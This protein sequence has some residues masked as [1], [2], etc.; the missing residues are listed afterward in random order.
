[1]AD[2]KFYLLFNNY[3]WEDKD[4]PVK[5]AGR[6][7][8]LYQRG[9]DIIRDHALL[10]ERTGFEGI[11]FTEQHANIEG[12]PEVTANPLLL[13]LF[14]A[15]QTSRIKVG[16]LGMTLPTANPL[17]VADQIAQL[18]QL[19]KGRVLAGFARGNTTRWADQYGQHIP[20]GSTRSDKSEADERNLRA[21]KEAWQIVKLAWTQ[22][23]FS[24]DGE[25]WKFPVAGT[26]WT[27]PHTREWGAG[28]DNDGN[29][30]GVS[31][32]PGPYQRPH[33]RVFA[34]MSAR[35]DTVRFW[36]RE[37]AS[38]MCLTPREDLVAGMLEVYA[39]ESRKVGRSPA[40]GEGI[41]VGGTFSI[42]RDEATALKRAKSMEEWD[43]FVYNVPP[44]NLPHPLA[45]NGT[46]AQI[47]DQIAG[48]HE[49]LGVTEFLLIDEFPAP[50]GREVAYEML[51]LFGTEVLPAF[52]SKPLSGASD[53]QSALA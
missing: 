7:T 8:D 11:F 15:G 50:H 13:S 14:V 6:R 5:L 44:Y 42:A 24:Y 39:D 53:R 27:Y 16:S 28:V 34:P 30:T 20:M 46:P 3:G 32:A 25:F 36:A 48:I 29:L 9:L 4:H 45:L 26:K 31:I 38:I 49:R 22:D 52:R 41:I 10:A 12:I 37:G 21:L 51:E 1:M 43:T 35:S 40:R 23:A 18:D 2:L 47:T 33:P 17:Y 19:T